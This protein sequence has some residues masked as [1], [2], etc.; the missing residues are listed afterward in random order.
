MARRITKNSFNKRGNTKTSKKNKNTLKSNITIKIG[1][2]LP[3]G[4]SAKGK[5]QEQQQQN[6]VQF[7]PMAQPFQAQPVLNESRLLQV[8]R[9]EIRGAQQQNQPVRIAEHP[10]VPV[11][12]VQQPDDE[13]KHSENP[14]ELELRAGREKSDKFADDLYRRRDEAESRKRERKNED[15][16]LDPSTGRRPALQPESSSSSSA[17]SSSSHWTVEDFD[18]MKVLKG[19]GQGKGYKISDIAIKNYL[20][21]DL[22]FNSSVNNMKRPKLIEHY[23]K[24]TK[25]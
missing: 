11:P 4:S 16:E 23:L 8:M 20:I 22:G 3:S 19:G 25:Y 1:S 14:E 24:G 18:E 12:V 6:K 2:N 21:N 10:P 17:S 9:D 15:V 5:G 7:I 13:N